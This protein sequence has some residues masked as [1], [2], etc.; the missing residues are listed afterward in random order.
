MI[1]IRLRVRNFMCY[2]DNVPPLELE[3]VKLACLSGDNGH[4]KSALL[5]AITW[6]LWGKARAKSDDELVH[7]G[8]SEMEVELDFELG[9]VRY[10]AIRRRSIKRSGK[11]VVS[12]PT[13]ELQVLGEGGYRT[14]SGN[15]VNETQRKISDILRMNYDTFINSSFVLQ[16][17]ADEFTIKPPAER[18]RVLADI[19]GLQVYDDLE[20]RAREMARQCES[21]RRELTVALREIEAELAKKPDYEAQLREAQ[22]L[23]DE[24]EQEIKAADAGLWLLRERKRELEQKA[25]YGADMQRQVTRLESE[26]QE[27]GRDIE[28]Q[29]RRNESFQALLERKVEITEGCARLE[30]VRA[31]EAALTS[32]MG[33]LLQ[34]NQTKSRLEREIQAASEALLREREGLRSRI[35]ELRRV[36]QQLP[37]WREQQAR[38]ADQ[39]ALLQDV[40]A[41]RDDQRSRLQSVQSQTELLRA[42]NKQRQQDMVSLRQRLDA[43]GRAGAVCPLCETDLGDE[44]RRAL[45]DKL[46]AEGQQ[47]GKGYRE[48]EAKV[49]ELEREAV[50]LQQALHRLDQ[51]LRSKAELERKAAFL[52]KCIADGQMAEA[53][54]E[55]LRPALEVIERQL[56]ERSYGLEQ[57][58]RLSEI[59]AQIRDL[60]YD[61]SKHEALQREAKSLAHYPALMDQ[62][63]SAES[64]VQSGLEKLE[65]LQKSRRNLEENLNYT[66]QML[67][68]VVRET[69]ALPEV[70]R[71][72]VE[73]EALVER[74]QAKGREGRERLGRVQQM[75]SHCRYL[76]KLQSEKMAA[77]AQTTERKAIYEELAAAFGRNGIQAMIIDGA[78]P[79]IEREAN[80]LLS[81][82][83]DNRMHVSFETQREAKTTGGVIE[84]LDI[85]IADELGQRAYELYSGGEA[86]RV[87]FAIRIALSKLLA[88]R[89]G[90]RLQTLI[91]DEGFGTQDT[92][93]RERL[94][95]CINSISEDFEKILVITHIQD[96][97]DAFP[98]RIDVVKTPEGSQIFVN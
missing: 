45:M 27:V 80:A 84:T 41:Q 22:K 83:T 77:Y 20:E 34:L 79:E 48:D 11:R 36:A 50:V 65:A 61:Q 74:L 46:R 26:L 71:S 9:G 17:R 55:Q 95:E 44:G 59:E 37:D 7:V 54:I 12:V 97:K 33:Q 51:S 14:I 29:K 75:L 47:I 23:V 89:A 87:N 60:G 21:E 49:K 2:A 90:A 35:A 3:G 72:L 31:E 30:T 57:Q 10:R 24:V 81:R 13:L 42:L 91:I 67:E 82:M 63:R 40:P 85:R 96:L 93:G 66:R 53:K 78:I 68:T 19:L 92:Q 4:G 62:L 76:E 5:E 1:P 28:E 6:V 15:S 58:Q 88:H 18:K 56:A 32:K 70:Q 38:L 39:L 16:N 86:F 98:V 73:A 69:S 8:R 52:E 94:V 25:A 64:L 43:L